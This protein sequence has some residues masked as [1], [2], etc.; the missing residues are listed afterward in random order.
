M[1][2]EVGDCLPEG[3]FGEVGGQRTDLGEGTGIST[4]PSVDIFFF[5]LLTMTLTLSLSLSL[6][7]WPPNLSIALWFSTFQ[8]GLPNE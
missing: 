6:S 1:G 3:E 2:K 7:L 4:G 5:S 8:I